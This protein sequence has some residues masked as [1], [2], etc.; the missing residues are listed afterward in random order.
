MTDRR[1]RDLGK[2]PINKGLAAA[3]LLA[4]IAAAIWLYRDMIPLNWK[5]QASTLFSAI[6]VDHGI[7][8]TM[9]DGIELAAS[10]YLP[11]QAGHPLPTILIRLPYGRLEYPEALNSALFFARNGYAV[12]VQDVRG[13][14]GSQGK[15][16]P[17]ESATSDGAA[18]LDWIV[19]QNWSNGKVGTFGCSALGE[20]QYS[21]ARA[22]HPAHAAMIASGAGGAWGVA[23]P[24]LDQGG[25]Y[26][27]GVL[28]LAPAF[29][30]SLQ[31][32]MRNPKLPRAA[33]VDISGVL[34][35]LP[36]IEMISRIQPGDNIF[37][38]Y[39]RMTPG[40]PGWRRLDL[41]MPDDRIDVPTLAINTWGDATVEATFELARMA[42]RQNAKADRQYVVI[43]PGNH[44]DHLSIVASGRFGDLEVGNAERPYRA[45]FLRWFDQKLSGQGDGLDN[46][47]PYQFYVLG[48]SRWLAAAQWPPEG[49]RLE[50]WFLGSGGH[51]NS[52]EGNGD[53]S[54]SPTSAATHDR[55]ASDPMQPVPSRGG[56]LCCTGGQAGPVDQ[57]DI[58]KREDVLVYTSPPLP[59]SMRI[60]GS[61]RAHLTIS[62]S[63]P[64]TDYIVRLTHVRPDGYSTNIQEGAL[65]L[66]Y[67]NGPQPAPPLAPGK[68]Y[69]I[70]VPMRSIAYYLPA[71]HR[72]RVHVAGSSFPRLERNL[73]TGGANFDETVGKVA[74]NTVHYGRG[75]DSY[76]ELPILSDKYAQDA[77]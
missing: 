77:P 61:L 22:E 55:F 48:E 56:P 69:A 33:G 23:L 36:L 64:D 66:R 26:E 5:M 7:R 41:V 38:D 72:L 42:H 1:P 35:T 39:L 37:T 17:W 6:R 20:L 54:P 70:S 43:A 75:G 44:C 24:N 58:E 74:Q 73:N 63:A 29:G 51:A 40:D 34:T 4:V 13:K 9:P 3:L 31:N 32:G 2:I 47:P 59:K 27:G 18:T 60:A 65:R 62:S 53:L 14:F 15:F 49:V 50:R 76:L 25:F 46:L 57:T 67:R 45:W 8:I 68:Q 16:A 21:L 12:L 28:Q 30:W 19:S 11:K 52:R 71:G 10:L